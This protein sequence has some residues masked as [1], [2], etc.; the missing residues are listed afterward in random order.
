MLRVGCEVTE[1]RI[2]INIPYTRASVNAALKI[3]QDREGKRILEETLADVG[4][5][6]LRSEINIQWDTYYYA[7]GDEELKLEYELDIPLVSI[8]GPFLLVT[9]IVTDLYRRLG[10]E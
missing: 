5:V 7:R 1:D 2:N 3:G 8:E 6:F 9:E 4:M 10:R